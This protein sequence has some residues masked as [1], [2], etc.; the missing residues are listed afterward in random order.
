MSP[1]AVISAVAIEAPCICQSLLPHPGTS[2]HPAIDLVSF[3]WLA[4]GAYAEQSIASG[5]NCFPAPSVGAFL[6][7]AS[8]WRGEAVANAFEG[9]Y[10]SEHRVL[11]GIAFINWIQ[12]A[13]QPR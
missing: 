5:M 11:E 8:S 2:T 6:S 1:K 12:C 7:L 3:M 13:L 4:A 10:C 9:S